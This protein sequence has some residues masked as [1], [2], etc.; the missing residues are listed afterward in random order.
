[1]SE[2]PA[3]EATAGAITVVYDEDCGVCG[4]TV[5]WI[6]RRDAR[7]TFRFVGNQSGLP[8]GVTAGETQETVVVLT[9]R[10]H[11]VRARAVSRILRELGFGWRVLGWL[12][13]VPGVSWLADF[14]Y[15]QFAKRRHLV[16]ARLG[17]AVCKVRPA[18][19]SR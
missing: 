19:S 14:G 12:M 17:L 16:S 5:E 6:R 18:A 8:E 1:M 10:E 4:A 15:R 7:G 2:V 13:R 9:A 11:L 3:S